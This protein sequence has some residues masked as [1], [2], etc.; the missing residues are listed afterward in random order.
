[1]KMENRE[2]HR[3]KFRVFITDY[4]AHLFIASG[5]DGKL[6]SRK[7]VSQ[8]IKEDNATVVTA[9]TVEEVKEAVFL[10]HPDNRQAR[11]T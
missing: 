7:S 2:R 1:M 8:I 11:M 4:F 10:M 5:V 3:K 9:V 6:S